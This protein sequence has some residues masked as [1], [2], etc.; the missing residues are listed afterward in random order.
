MECK[1]IG[2]PKP[3]I[4][5]Y[6]EKL[7]IVS[8]NKCSVYSDDGGVCTLVVQDVNYEDEGTYKAVAS[9][10]FGNV[11]CTAKLIVKG[12]C[13]ILPFFSSKR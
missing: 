10:E 4:K 9:N 6:K 7:E 8:T 2:D 11:F 5:W 12:R 3:D 13:C 1:A